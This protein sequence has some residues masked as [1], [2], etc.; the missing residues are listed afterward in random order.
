VLEDERAEES[1][2]D[3]TQR[4][5]AREKVGTVEVTEDPVKVFL[6]QLV[7]YKPAQ[8]CSVPYQLSIPHAPCSQSRPQDVY[9]TSG[10]ALF[11]TC[12]QRACDIVSALYDQPFAYISSHSLPA[13]ILN[14]AVQLL[15]TEI[16]VG[17]TEDGVKGRVDLGPRL[18][19]E[20]PGIDF[21]C[22]TEV[23][24]EQPF[25]TAGLHAGRHGLARLC[26]AGVRARGEVNHVSA[27]RQA[28]TLA[29]EAVHVGG[30]H[31][32]G[33]RGRGVGMRR[34]VEAGALARGREGGGRIGLLLGR[35][36]QLLLGGEGVL[37]FQRA[38]FDGGHWT[39]GQ[40]RRGLL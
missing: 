2:C 12:R 1:D 10:Q 11:D 28:G 18:V 8:T 4:L 3:V 31:G 17:L 36:G 34:A 33:W 26:W 23:L 29:G 37:P 35:E 9:G 7:S 15:K 13:N 40:W 39:G 6:W 24:D 27:G 16:D 20:G 5:V 21:A 19:Q 38:G 32:C 30:A 14:A 25:G 22:G